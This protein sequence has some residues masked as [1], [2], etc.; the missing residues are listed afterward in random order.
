MPLTTANVTSGPAPRQ[1]SK[2]RERS[3]SVTTT[4][5]A[6]SRFSP[7]RTVAP[8]CSG[9]GRARIWSGWRTPP[10]RTAMAEK[11][12]CSETKAPARAS[13]KAFVAP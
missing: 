6:S 8:L 9:A 1:R 3:G 2:R 13:E 12:G 7:G 10:M 4:E 5:R 11:P